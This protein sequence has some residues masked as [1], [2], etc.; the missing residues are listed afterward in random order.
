MHQDQTVFS[1]YS[2]IQADGAASV[3][4][5]PPTRRP[6]GHPPSPDGGSLRSVV[7]QIRSGV[8]VGR[9]PEQEQEALIRF[10]V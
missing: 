1:L 3:D 10:Q 6:D 7:F 2:S 8:N 5:H 9:Q 4:R